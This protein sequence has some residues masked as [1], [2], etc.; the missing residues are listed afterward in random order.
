MLRHD[1]YR[2]MVALGLLLIAWVFIGAVSAKPKLI[3]L[4]DFVEYQFK[5]HPES[6][7]PMAKMK[8]GE[9]TLNVE[10]ALTSRSQMNGLMHRYILPQNAGMLFVFAKEAPRSFWMKN[11]KI[12]LDII[13]IDGK[14]V[15]VDIVKAVPCIADPCPSYPSKAP[16]Q[17]VLELGKN[18]SDRLGIEIGYQFRLSN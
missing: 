4:P 18:E 9:A 3:E 15:V 17:Y 7:L 11:T 10:L 13:Y 14:G 5:M 8:A 1:R 12:P 6:N 16:A 2:M